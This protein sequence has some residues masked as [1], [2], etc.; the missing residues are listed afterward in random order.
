MMVHVRDTRYAIESLNTV[1]F[2]LV[3]IFY[4]FTVIPERYRDIYQYN[5]VAALVLSMRVVLLDGKSPPNTLLFKLAI[6]AFATLGVGLMVFRK[7]KPSFYD[8][9]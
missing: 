4:D 7:L 2:W 1:L 3:P 6:V 5:P 8:Y 9:L